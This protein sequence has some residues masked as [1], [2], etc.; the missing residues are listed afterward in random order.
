MLGY[1]MWVVLRL[2]VLLLFASLCI[3]M[4]ASA[5]GWVLRGGVIAY[6]D[7]AGVKLVDVASGYVLDVGQHSAS[8]PVWSP[9]GRLLAMLIPHQETPTTD[10]AILRYPSW[11]CDHTL[12]VD[13]PLVEL[14][15]SPDGASFVMVRGSGQIHTLAREGDDLHFVA[16]GQSP[17]WSPDSRTILYNNINP[18]RLNNQLWLADLDDGT[19]RD[20]TSGAMR[21]W[22]P[23]WSP[24]GRWIVFASNR[25]DPE[26]DLYIMPADCGA[27]EVCVRSARRLTS[28]RGADVS[29][30][31]SPDGAWVA[32]ASARNGGY[33]VF[34][35][36]T[37]GSGERPITQMISRFSGEPAWKP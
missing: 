18:L 37:D 3:V 16:Y 36:R 21:N 27:S 9:D 13:A 24:D 6:T 26:G 34:V 17:S 12:L 35:I 31:W 20:L 28:A 8:D 4:L 1:H 29:P 23:A 2:A 10:I 11:R 19:T 14:A 5:V 7:D 22:S 25:D 33:Q 15:W 30:A 32:F